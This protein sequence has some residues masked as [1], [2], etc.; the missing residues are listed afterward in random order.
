MRDTQRVVHKAQETGGGSVFSQHAPVF[1]KVQDKIILTKNL[2]RA[3][4]PKQVLGDPQKVHISAPCQLSA[5]LNQTIK[6]VP[7]VMYTDC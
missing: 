7:A 5:H 1:R 2:T 6:N 4:F 3:V